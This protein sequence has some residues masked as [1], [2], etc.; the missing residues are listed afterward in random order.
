M[1]T[2]R[3]RTVI[4]VDL[5]LRARELRS[6]GCSFPEIERRL[7]S[8]ASRANVIRWGKLDA[9][10]I[11]AIA[12]VQRTIKKLRSGVDKVRNLKR[13]V[14]QFD[15]MENKLTNTSEEF[16]AVMKTAMPDL[17]VVKALPVKPS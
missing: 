12:V 3:G 2:L 11:E 16:A 9:E 10:Q 4:P 1:T 6:S 13:L 7:G 14:R 17:A 5:I 8:K 15:E